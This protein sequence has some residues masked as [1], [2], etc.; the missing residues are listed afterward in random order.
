MSAKQYPSPTVPM[1]YFTE[2][3]AGEHI[4]TINISQRD[5]E[6]YKTTYGS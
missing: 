4:S 6:C 5:P 3:L 1:D 2:N